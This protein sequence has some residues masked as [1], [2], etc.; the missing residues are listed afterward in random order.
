MKY[1]KRFMQITLIYAFFYTS[2]VVKMGYVHKEYY[3]NLVSYFGPFGF[4]VVTVAFYIFG[5]L[6]MSIDFTHLNKMK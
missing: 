1:I 2:F 4:V 5:F 6:A 3:W